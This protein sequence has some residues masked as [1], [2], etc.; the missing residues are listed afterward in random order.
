MHNIS[1]YSKNK[2]ILR[3]I[4]IKMYSDRSGYKFF[5]FVGQNVTTEN[6][7]HY[8]NSLGD[9]HQLDWGGPSTAAVAGGSHLVHHFFSLL[10]LLAPPS[11]SDKDSSCKCQTEIPSFH[12]QNAS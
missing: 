4:N 5:P 2:N 1:E 12:F 6:F 7:C 3:V 10:S 9:L 8:V 11:F